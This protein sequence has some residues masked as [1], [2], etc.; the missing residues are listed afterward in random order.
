MRELATVERYDIASGVWTTVA[1]LP[2][3]RSNLAAAAVG[4]KI[5]VFGGCTGIF[6]GFLRDV[7]G[8]RPADGHVEYHTDQHADRTRWYMRWRPGA[9]PCT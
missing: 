7:D 5:Y 6:N 2:S 9:A 8:V 1:P 3:A 4:G